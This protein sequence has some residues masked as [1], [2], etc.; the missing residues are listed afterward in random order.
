MALQSS[1]LADMDRQ[2]LASIYQGRSVFITGHTG[3]KGS[4][5]ALWLARMGSQVH[6]YS[7]PPP[8]DPS[9]F[10]LS[11]VQE[12]LATHC[13]ADIRDSCRLQQALDQAKPDIVFH[14]AAQSLVRASYGAPF[15]TMEI[16]ILGSLQL[17]QCLKSLARPCA[18]VM[19]T[20]DKCYKNQNQVWGYREIDPLGGH[21]PYSASKAAAEICIASYRDS[22]FPVERI[23]EHGVKIAT[24]R[25]GNV[26]GGGDWAQDRI[27]PDLVQNIINQKATPIRNP[28]SIRPWQHV[29][30]PLYGYLVLG[31]HLMG[32]DDPD[33]CS[34]WNFGPLPGDEATVVEMADLFYTLWGSGQWRHDASPLHPGEAK[35][36]RLCI[37]KAVS[38]LNWSP[39]WPFHE[40]MK[41]TVH[42]YHGLFIDK[43]DA[44][45]LCESD[46]EAYE[47]AIK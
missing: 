40:T 1:A 6:G 32:S 44:R 8:T 46:I 17:L 28:N 29:L 25:A 36:L 24:A 35:T 21:D 9:N 27:V 39:R 13:L 34:A 11:R 43:W 3:F 5:L 45:R 14:L 15:D 4:W 41:H 2:Q 38:Q 31:A 10:L 18:V 26:I 37:D 16:N 47:K 42:W 30:E 33:W 7:L 20:T 22:F 23:A 12:V 19:I